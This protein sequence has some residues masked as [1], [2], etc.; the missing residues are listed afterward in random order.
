MR[1]IAFAFVGILCAQLTGWSQPRAG[2]PEFDVAS[3]KLN[4]DGI[5]GSLVRTPGGLTATNAGFDRL[6][7]M[8]FQTHLFDLSAV[9]EPV[10]SGRFDIVA[11]A[12]SKISGDQYW[13]M[14]RS[15]LEDRFKLKYHHETKDAQ[16]Y[17]LILAKK[18]GF[19]PKISL[20]ADPDCPASPSGSTFCGVSVRAGLMIGQRVSMPRIARELSPFADR[21]VQDHTGLT[22]SFDFQL[23]WTPDLNV[24][25]DG[26]PKL[27][28][29]T[30][31]DTSGPSFFSAIKEQLG[32]KLESQRGRIEVLVVD[33]A[34]QPSDN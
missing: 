6:I 9:P 24:S 3:V 1:F 5:G 15:L 2:R 26:G 21:P 14:L 19:G 27:L 25:G 33:R 16:V 28:N 4:R 32:L 13:E 31:L 30:P 34:E 11:R 8:A 17:A 10:R 23:T 29:G 20:S 7:E 18:S 12:G 22:G